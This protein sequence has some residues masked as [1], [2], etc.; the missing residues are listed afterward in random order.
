MG[1]SFAGTQ[2]EI[3]QIVYIA[4]AL[5]AHMQTGLRALFKA[6]P[7]NSSI[8]LLTPISRTISDFSDFGARRKRFNIY[9]DC[10]RP[11][12]ADSDSDS[13]RICA[14]P[15]VNRTSWPISDTKSRHFNLSPNMCVIL[16]PWERFRGLF[17]A[18]SMRQGP[19][20]GGCENHPRSP[21]WH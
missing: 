14:R 16:G 20:S 15:V 13:D 10:F 8:S 1:K 4:R 5:M 19:E 21:G 7:P 9:T 2:F 12:D 11:D 17:S 18:D 3:W 6:H